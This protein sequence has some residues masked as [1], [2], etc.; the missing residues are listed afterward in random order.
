[1]S[2]I[3]TEVGVG[4]CPERPEGFGHVWA[5]ALA[6]G[7]ESNPCRFCGTSGRAF[8]KA[9]CA[10]RMAGFEGVRLPGQSGTGDPHKAW[11][12]GQPPEMAARAAAIREDKTRRDREAKS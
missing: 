10:G 3:E 6:S 9:W 1:M 8:F 2:A 11:P 12:K 7:D 4:Q 5:G